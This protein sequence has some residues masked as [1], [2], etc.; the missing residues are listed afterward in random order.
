MIDNAHVGGVSSLSLSHNHRFVVTGGL[1]GEVRLWELRSRELVSHLKEHKQNITCIAL[2]QDDTLALSASRDRCVLRWDL[3][4][5]VGYHRMSFIQ[6]YIHIHTYIHT[7]THSNI[8]TYIHTYID[9]YIL[10]Y[11]HI[12]IHTYIH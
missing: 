4:T 3:R 11:I 9:T 7:H 12:Y 6:T 2:S 5:E 8:H 10:P 1:S